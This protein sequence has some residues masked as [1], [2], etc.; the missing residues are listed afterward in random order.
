MKV[1]A[2]ADKR[3]RRAQVSPARRRSWLPSW[4]VIAALVAGCS[5]GLFGLYW[6]AGAALHAEALTVTR[7]TVTGNART[8]RGE[9]LAL[10]DGIRGENMVTLDLEGW[11]QKLLTSPWVADAAL[12]RQLPGT[13]AVALSE[14]EPIGI[15]RIADR[16]Y[17]I[18]QRG[19]IID[20]FGP[21]YAEFNLPIIDGLDSGTA[22]GGTLIDDA[23][24]ALAGRLLADLQREPA[25]AGRVSQVDVS[26]PR[27]ATVIL[28]GDT[29]IVRVGTDRF[30]E[31]VQSYIDLAPALRDRVPQIDYVDLR[32]DER[33][34]VKPL[35]A[36]RRTVRTGGNE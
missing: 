32:F 15:G 25:L 12:R 9:V 31:R 21:N 36:A 24:A 19:M 3:F 29:T 28:K 13:L 22:G 30:V 14:R 2:P 33:V 5:T 7:I 34:Y 20:E 17:L 4:R 27:D 26:D 16:L 11:R 1:A 35:G 18:D 6:L 8:S 10:L 23:R